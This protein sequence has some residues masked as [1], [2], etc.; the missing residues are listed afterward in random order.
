MSDYSDLED[1]I[2][3]HLVGYV[4]EVIKRQYSYYPEL[5]T[6]FWPRDLAYFRQREAFY[7]YMLHLY[8]RPET[9]SRWGLTAEEVAEYIRIRNNPNFTEFDDALEEVSMSHGGG[10]VD[11]VRRML[12]EISEAD[13]KVV[14][15]VTTEDQGR[16]RID[17]TSAEPWPVAAKIFVLAQFRSLYTCET[18]GRPGQYRRNSVGWRHTRCSEHRPPPPNDGEVVYDEKK[19]PWRRMSDGVY[20]YDVS[21]DKLVREERADVVEQW[22]RGEITGAA[23]RELTG[24][25]SFGE[26][27]KVAKRYDVEIRFRPRDL[28]SAV[29]EGT[30]TDAAA[31]EALGASLADWIALKV[32]LK[33]G[34]DP[35]V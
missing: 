19:S 21:E 18:C 27:Y 25:R 20:K 13:V 2:R 23:A 15:I 35:K 28:L 31:A 3:P 9:A 11:I 7:V 33:A 30:M 1:E 10:W 5:E 34:S 6:D 26:L 24:A 32:A 4:R 29:E 16:L 8:A 12:K 22:Q 17:Y 14:G